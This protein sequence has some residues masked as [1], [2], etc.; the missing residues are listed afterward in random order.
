ML[1][2]DT[3]QYHSNTIYFNTFSALIAVENIVGENLKSSMIVPPPTVLDRVLK[4]LFHEGTVSYSSFLFLFSLNVVSSAA[5]IYMNC[6][7]LILII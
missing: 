5:D 6:Y 1:E 7:L 3:G 2:I 4:E